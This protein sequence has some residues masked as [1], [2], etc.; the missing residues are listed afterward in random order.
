MSNIQARN[1]RA[2][3]QSLHQMEKSAK[4][5]ASVVVLILICIVLSVYSHAGMSAQVFTDAPVYASV[6]DSTPSSSPC[7]RRRLQ[8]ESCTAADSAIYS[9]LG[10]RGSDWTQ[11]SG[12]DGVLAGCAQSC[13]IQVLMGAQC[14]NDCIVEPLG[15]SPPC[16]LCAGSFSACGV[17]S[18][19]TECI[20]GASAACDNCITE[21]CD[22]DFNT[23][24]GFADS[25]YTESTSPPS[26]PPSPPSPTSPSSPPLSPLSPSSPPLPP[27]QETQ[28]WSIGGAADIS[29]FKSLKLLYSNDSFILGT[30]LLLFS[31]IK[32]YAECLS[33]LLLWFLPLSIRTRGQ[34][35]RWINRGSRWSMLDVLVVM[36]MC[37]AINFKIVAGTVSVIMEVSPAICTF[38]TMAL[39]LTPVG[40]WM[41]FRATALAGFVQED[42]AHLGCLGRPLPAFLDRAIQSR[43]RQLL[44]LVA[45]AALG[46]TAAALF[47]SDAIAYEVLDPLTRQLQIS[48]YSVVD[49]MRASSSPVVSSSATGVFLSFTFFVVVVF[50]PLTAGLA[51]VVV[52]VVPSSSKLHRFALRWAQAF[53]AYASLDVLLVAVLTFSSEFDRLVSS[54]ASQIEFDRCAGG[55]LE[56]HAEAPIG[57][58][59]L[60]AIP[61]VIFTWIAQFL[62]AVHAASLNVGQGFEIAEGSKVQVASLEGQKQSLEVSL[63]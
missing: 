17:S 18:C 60:I 56:I 30:I 27:N 31:G 36:A 42:P 45:P 21:N 24:T 20:S 48:Q 34:V 15:F 50:A 23:C 4:T 57:P 2:P 26:S 61:A 54:F 39:V 9:A 14:V 49:L 29:F 40:E 53:N 63:A 19:A 51:M 7:S 47:V 8:S 11:P 46:F 41:T 32:P 33:L 44:L 38:A 37:S 35:L 6:Y 55:G 43:P 10:G 3:H 1:S 62:T 52:A 28:F 13:G 25:T 12:F 22:P 16:S 58:G 59:L 5:S